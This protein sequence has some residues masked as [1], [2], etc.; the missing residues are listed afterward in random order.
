ML[1]LV[2][3]NQVVCCLAEG[4]TQDTDCIKAALQRAGGAH[5][6]ASVRM[7]SDEPDVRAGAVTVEAGVVAL[8]EARNLTACR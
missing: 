2:L 4:Y 3:I 1:L 6:S 5:G 8:D 7:E